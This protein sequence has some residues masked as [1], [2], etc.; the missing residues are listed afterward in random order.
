[1]REPHAHDAVVQPF[2]DDLQAFGGAVTVALCGSWDHEPPCPLAPHAT[3]A[4][5]SGGQ[6]R[7]RV[8]FAAEPDDV[9]EVRSRI[10]SALRAGSLVGPTGV[11]TRWRYVSGGP[12]E[13]APEESAHA[14]RLATS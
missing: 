1:M 7:V 13:P 5:R 6:V 10:E 8:L 2:G 9:A 12:S 4:V 3:A 14:A 11:R